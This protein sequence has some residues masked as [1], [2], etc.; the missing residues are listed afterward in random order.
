MSE[1][2]TH[3]D[4]TERNG[5]RQDAV[6]LNRIKLTG[7]NL[8]AKEKPSTANKAVTFRTSLN[9][10]HINHGIHGGAAVARAA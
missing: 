7:V 1:N 4:T 10:C 6:N 2:A 3:L 9:I 5:G 8:S